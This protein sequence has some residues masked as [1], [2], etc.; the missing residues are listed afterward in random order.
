[1]SGRPNNF[2]PAARHAARKARQARAAETGV[3]S[4]NGIAATLNARGVLTPAGCG[5][6]H[7]TQVRR[8][9]ARMPG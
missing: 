9:L 5:Q 4:L 1:M 2:P 3:T 7:A 8:V 6:W